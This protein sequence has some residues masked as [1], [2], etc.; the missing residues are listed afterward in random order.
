MAEPQKNYTPL[1]IGA[2]VTGLV[3]MVLSV[4]G[5]I[6]FSG[7][8]Q[9]AKNEANH[10]SNLPA[11]V[12]RLE[13][14]EEQQRS[15]LDRRSL[16][17]QFEALRQII[18]GVE[19][20]LGRRIQ[21]EVKDPLYREIDILTQRIERDEKRLEVLEGQVFRGKRQASLDAYLHQ[22]PR[23]ASLESSACQTFPRP[24]L[25]ALQMKPSAWPKKH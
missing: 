9:A 13:A 6:L 19:R 22:G 11:V 10:I 1:I 25:A 8:E 12:A 21:L 23:L 17:A 2:I 16:D 14:V 20:Q 3:G 15:T 18:E 4:I 5:A 7:T 24:T